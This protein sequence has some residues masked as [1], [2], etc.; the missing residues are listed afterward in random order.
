M[1]ATIPPTPYTWVNSE[2]LL[3]EDMGERIEDVLNFLMN[4]PMVRLRK[5]TSQ[6]FTS[7][8]PTNVIWD[9]VEI[10]NTNMWDASQPTRIKPSVP[11]WY[12]G[13][14]GW[15]FAFNASGER[16]MNIF[17]NGLSSAAT[18]PNMIANTG[19]GYA[20]SAWTTVSRGNVFI[21]PFNGTTDYVEMQLYQN[22][23]GNLAM[24][25][26]SQDA[27]ADFTLRWLAAL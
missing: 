12:V 13:S 27:Q 26:G 7:A 15:S 5:I 22:S 8:T 24:Q 3:A 25:F 11:G 16:E 21:E 10:E 4:P 19:Q 2:N 1:A 17:K 23:G 6:T 9:F 20:S 18:D 14:C